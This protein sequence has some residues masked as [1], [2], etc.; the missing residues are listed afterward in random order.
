M[1]ALERRL[2]RCL[3]IQA[4]VVGL[5]VLSPVLVAVAVAVRLDSA[6][7]VLYR[8]VR[9]GR[10]GRPFRILK[11]RTMVEDAEALGG[12]TTAAGD[13]RITRIGRWLRR[14]KVD[15]LPQLLN[16]LW[17]DMSLV[18][19]R[20]EVLEYTDAYTDDERAIL[21]VTPGI[22]DISSL[23]FIDLQSHVGASEADAAFRRDVLP[24]KN[25]LRLQYVREQSF[26][27]DV[28]ILARTVFSLAQRAAGL[29]GERRAG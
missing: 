4:A 11:F 12:T 23:E 27:G 28:G 5:T 22:T 9:A 14:Y 18:G 6:G 26:V 10:G 13:P 15:E 16:V 29:N 7:P 17:G 8:G 20:P 2:K 25:R 24:R 3:D 21:S 1:N 19:P